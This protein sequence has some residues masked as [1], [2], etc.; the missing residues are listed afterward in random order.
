MQLENT[1]AQAH[2]FVASGEHQQ[3][4]IVLQRK[5]TDVV[6]AQR[7]IVGNAVSY[8]LSSVETGQAELCGDPQKT[9]PVADDLVDCIMRQ[10]VLGIPAARN[11]AGR[12]CVQIG[13]GLLC[14]EPRVERHEP[15]KDGVT[16]AKPPAQSEP[17]RSA[18]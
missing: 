11:E 10:S 7:K 13:R 6:A 14:V 5:R 9:M 3:R 8:E 1:I 12:A 17:G 15:H 2:Q 4:V 18:G 16:D